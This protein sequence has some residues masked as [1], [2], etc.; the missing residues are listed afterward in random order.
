MG[1][2]KLYGAVAND[3]R[4]GLVR[5]L[6]RG[7]VERMREPLSTRPDVMLG[8]RTWAAG[9]MLNSEGNYGPNKLTFGHTG[10]GGSLA[11]AISTPD[12]VSATCITRWAPT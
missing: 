3:G 11:A 2:A 5:L 10:W 7:T 12:S 8:A 1:L 9:V 4:L 6:S